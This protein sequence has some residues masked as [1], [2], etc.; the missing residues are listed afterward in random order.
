LAASL[1]TLLQL[2]FLGRWIPPI[3]GVVLLTTGALTLAAH[4][5]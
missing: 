2:R 3:S 4:L 5:A 1:P